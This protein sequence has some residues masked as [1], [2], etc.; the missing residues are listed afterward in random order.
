M[1][2]LHPTVW[3]ILLL[4][5]IVLVLGALNYARY[6]ADHIYDERRDHAV[7]KE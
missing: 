5:S 6:E 2:G 4:A 1:N 3:A 7:K